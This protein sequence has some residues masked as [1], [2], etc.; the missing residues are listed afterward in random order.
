MTRRFMFAMSCIALM[1][2][3]PAFAQAQT[4]SATPTLPES[5][6]NAA[7]FSSPFEFISAATSIDQF[8]IQASALA[9]QL[10]E[11]REVKQFAADTAAIHRASIEAI[12]S[13]G[14]NEGVE[15]AKPSVDGE[16]KGMIGKLE[17]QK[18]AEF[19]RSYLAAQVYI[20]QRAI[21][22]YRGYASKGGKLGQYAASTL[23]KIV[24]RYQIA[25]QLAEK[26][27]VD[28]AQKPATAY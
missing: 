22:V 12:R 14:A 25:I 20:H 19:D 15:I 17:P 4:G 24:E 18:G 1:A 3:L 13:I 7:E 11:A 23:P 21:A 28:A 10:A 26:L 5:Q 8:E 2:P 27:G 9:E 16:Q 6:I